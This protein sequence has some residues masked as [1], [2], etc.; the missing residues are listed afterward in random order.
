MKY[1]TFPEGKKPH[2]PKILYQSKLSLKSEGK[3]RTSQT[4]LREIVAS[5]LA[6]QEMLNSSER[7]KMVLVRNMDIHKGRVSVKKQE[8]VK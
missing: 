7:R 2:Q 8:I 4:K 6:M 1:F 5:R 3:E